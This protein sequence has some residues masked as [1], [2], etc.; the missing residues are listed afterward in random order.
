[1]EKK[2]KKHSPGAIERTE[3]DDVETPAAEATEVWTEVL[4]AVRADGLGKAVL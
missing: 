1:M 4:K 2:Q 3:T